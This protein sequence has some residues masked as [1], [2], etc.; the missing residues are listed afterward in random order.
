MYQSTPAR[1]FDDRRPLGR[2]DQHRPR[3]LPYPEESR[4]RVLHRQHNS[5]LSTNRPERRV[6]REE[7]GARQPYRRVSRP[8]DSLEEYPATG[9]RGH[10]IRRPFNQWEEEG[11]GERKANLST[12]WPRRE[13]EVRRPSA[14]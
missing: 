11:D 2:Q 4:E 9:R 3:D 7:Q 14:R 12:S 5:G 1:R 6:S 8:R 10:P 13:R